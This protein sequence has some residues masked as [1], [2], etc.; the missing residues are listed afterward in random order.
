MDFILE[1]QDMWQALATTHKPIVIYGMGNGAE[2]ALAKCQEYGI[3]IADIFASD[4]FVRGQV[5]CN[6]KILKYSDIVQ[7][8]GEDIIILLAFG[9][10]S[11]VM[12]AHFKDLAQRHELLAPNFPLFG[13]K[14][15]CVQ[16]LEDY[17]LELQEVYELLAD[18]H[19]RK[20]F[21]GICNYK[22]SGKVKYLFAIDSDRRQDIDTLLKLQDNEIYMDLGAYNGDTVEEFLELTHGQY[23]KIIAVEPDRK[24]FKKLHKRM[25]EQQIANLEMLQLGIWDSETTLTFNHAGGRASA[26]ECSSEDSICVNSVDNILGNSP[27]SFIKMDVEGAELESLCGATH[28]LATYRPKLLVAG[29]HHDDDF[30]RIPLLIKKLNPNYRIF[31]RK[32]PYLPAWEIN[33]FAS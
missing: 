14:S 3:T 8:H 26:L 30:F 33:I 5:F 4:E 31:L 32:H 25:S 19:S 7:K 29:Y 27:A 28:T 9:S 20:V 21:A 17:A 6:Y 2:K 18:E 22:I 12:L 24:N 13:T 11:A 16:W 1:R 10:E 15:F 23:Q